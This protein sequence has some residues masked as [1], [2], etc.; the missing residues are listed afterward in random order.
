MRRAITIWWVLACATAHAQTG[1]A[2]APVRAVRGL[3]AELE[4]E[5]PATL[6]GPTEQSPTS[7]F[8]V[9]VSPIP[10]TN[11]QRI[12]FV[13]G[14]AGT[15][16]LREFLE[17]EDGQSLEDLPPLPV[18]VVTQLPP[19]HGTDLFD[20]GESQFDWQAHYRELLWGAVIVW[21]VIPVAYFLI[22]AAR[23]PPPTPDAEAGESV[24]TLE[25]RLREVLSTAAARD[26]SIR[27][28]GQLELL[29]LRYLGA[30]LKLPEERARELADVLGALREHPETRDFVSALERW[31]HAK[32]GETQRAHAAAALEELRRTRL[33]QPESAEPAEVGP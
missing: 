27:E 12:E 26:L 17:R 6:R 24:Q 1:S 3:A 25:D 18:E 32:G 9:R 7:P 14:V 30:R 13:G 28:R 20:S 22:R 31:L 29:V 8:M 11:R 19:D 21:A 33:T 2:P 10:G 23:K 16:D 15:Y 4:V 5:Y